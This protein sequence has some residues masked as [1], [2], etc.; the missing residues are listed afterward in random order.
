MGHGVEGLDACAPLC[1]NAGPKLLPK[2][3][4]GL[5]VCVCVLVEFF[6]AYTAGLVNMAQ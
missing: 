3:D 5:C 2:M 1:L 4:A 6:T